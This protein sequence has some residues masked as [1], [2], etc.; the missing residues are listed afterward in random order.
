[1]KSLKKIS[2]IFLLTFFIGMGVFFST[3]QQAN[4]NVLYK[5]FGMVAEVCGFGQH[6]ETTYPQAETVYDIENAILFDGSSDYLSRTPSSSGNTKAWTWSGWVQRSKLG[7]EQYVFNATN[8][9]SENTLIRFQ[10]DDKLNLRIYTG[11]TI[12]GDLI[13]SALYRDAT[14]WMHI[15]AVID[16]DNTIAG[17]RMR[18]YVN[19]VEVTDF[20]TDIN[21]NVGQVSVVN[22][23]SYTHRMGSFEGAQHYHNGYASD[24]YF[25][26]GQALAA[27]DF[28]YEDEYGKWQPKAYAGS[29]GTNGFYLDF[30]DSSNL[31]KDASG[32]GNNWTVNGS[33]EQVTSTPTNTYAT[34]NLLDKDSGV[35]LSN[36]N[37]TATANTNALDVR[38]TIAVNSGKYSFE[39]KVGVNASLT[40][41]G[42]ADTAVLLENSYANGVNYRSDA[43]Q[44]LEGSSSSY[45]DTYT[46]GDLIRGEFDID[47]GTI[48]FFKNN[49]SQGTISFT[50]AGRYFTPFVRFGGS[51]GSGT[52]NFTESAWEN[53]PTS[54]FQALSIKNLATPTIKKANE[55]FEVLTY[56][57]NGSTQTITGTD[58][59][60]VDQLVWMKSRSETRAH[61][62]FDSVRGGG[63]TIYSSA[64]DSEVTNHDRGYLYEFN[65]DGFTVGA[66]AIDAA[67]TN[68]NGEG[69]VAWRWRAGDTQVTNTDGSITS[70][71]SAN[72]QAGFSI[73][74]YTGNGVVGATIG[75]GLGG[76][77]TKIIVKQ[78]N[79]TT[80]WKTYHESLG[81]QYFLRFDT[82][83]AIPDPDRWQNT[84]PTDSVITLGIENTR[85]GYEYIAYVWSEVEGFSKFGSYTGNG[86]TDGPFVYTGF[87]PK[88]VMVKRADGS[89]NWAVLDSERSAYNPRNSI[90]RPDLSSTE[91]SGST[92]DV[93]ILS[94]GVKLRATDG[95]LN[96][97]GGNYIYMAFA[98]EPLKVS[99]NTKTA[100]TDYTNSGDYSFEDGTKLQ[101]ANGVASLKDSGSGYPVDEILTT[102]TDDDGQLNITG[103]FDMEGVDVTETKE[104]VESVGSSV[105]FDETEQQYLTWTPETEG[106]RK[107][108]TMSSWVKRSKLGSAGD[109][110]NPI[111]TVDVNGSQGVGIYFRSD[112]TLE[113]PVQWTG[114]WSGYLRTTPVFRDASD[115]AHVMLAVDTT[116]ETNTNRLKLYVDG[117]QVTSFSTETYP[118]QNADTSFN[119]ARAHEVGKLVNSAHHMDGYLANVHFVD[120]QALEPLNFGQTE[121]ATGKWVPK[122][123][124]G[125]YGTNGFHLDFSNESRLGDDAATHD[126]DGY[127]VLNSLDKSSGGVI[128]NGGKTIASNGSNTNI[129]STLSI[130]ETGKWSFEVNVDVV[131][132]GNAW[133][134]VDK[135][136]PIATNP[137]GY[138]GTI[139]YSSAL[140]TNDVVRFEVDADNSL[141]DIFKNDVLVSAD[142][143]MTAGVEYMVYCRTSTSGEAQSTFVFD[144]SSWTHTPTTGFQALNVNNLPEPSTYNT[145]EHFEVLTWTGTGSAQTIT[146]TDWGADDQLIWLKDRTGT[147][148]HQ[149]TD[150][151]RG[152]S[153]YIYTNSTV[154][155]SGVDPSIVSSINNDGI[156][157]GSAN[158]GNANGS[159]YVAWR[160]RAGQQTANTDGT[161]NSTVSHNPTLGFSI[162]KYTGNGSAGATIG[163]GGSKK[164]AIVIVKDLSNTSNWNI[165]HSALTGHQV[166][167][168]TTGA[169][170]TDY[171]A[172]N[173]TVP[174]SSVFT[175]GTSSQ[176]N[177]SGNEYIAYIF[178]ESDLVKPFSYTGNGSTDGP[179]VYTGGEPLFALNKQTNA[180]G[181]A[182]LIHDKI[183]GEDQGLKPNQN[184]GEATFNALDFEDMGLKNVST[185]STFNASGGS[186][187]GLAIVG[188]Q[189]Q[190][191]LTGND[192]DV[193]GSPEQTSD[194]PT[195]N[196]A[197]LNPVDTNNQTVNF[198]EG[199]LRFVSGSGDRGGVR[200]TLGAANKVVRY[201][202]TINSGAA[203]VRVGF[204]KAGVTWGSV[205][206]DLGN[207][208]GGNSFGF[209]LGNGYWN[210]KTNNSTGHGTITDG[211]DFSVEFNQTTG[212]VIVRNETTSTNVYDT[213]LVDVDGDVWMA[214][215]KE[216]NGSNA[217][218]ITLRFAKDQWKYTPQDASATELSVANLPTPTDKLSNHFETLLYTG[219]GSSQNITGT[220]WGGDDQLVWIKSRN[221][222]FNHSLTD[223]VRGATKRLMSDTTDAENTNAQTLTSFS[224]NGFSVGSNNTENGS[225]TNFVAWRFRAGQQETNND[226]TIEATVSAN[227]TSGFSIV[228]YTGNDTS[229]QSV[230]HGLDTAPG[231]V[232][233]KAL[234]SLNGSQSWQVWH[235]DLTP[236]TFLQLNDTGSAYSE[237]GAPHARFEAPYADDQVFYIGG[238]DAINGSGSEFIAYV[239]AESDFIDIGSYTGN[240]SSDGPFVYMDGKPAFNITKRTDS[241]NNW[242]MTDST[243]SPDNPVN[244]FIYPDVYNAETTGVPID[245]LST[246]IK[247]RTTNAI[248]NASGGSYV[249]LTF[250][251]SLG[252]QNANQKVYYAVSFDDRTTF[253]TWDATVSAWRNIAQLSAGTWAFNSATSG[254]EAWTNCT[255]NDQEDCLSQAFGQSTN[256]MTG[257]QFEALKDSDF[258]KSGGWT[259]DSDTIDVAIGMSTNTTVSTPTVDS[260]EFSYLPRDTQNTSIPYTVDENTTYSSEDVSKAQVANGEAKLVANSGD[261]PTDKIYSVSTSNSSQVDTANLASVNSVDVTETTASTDYE[262]EN[263][264]VLDSSGEYFSKTFSSAESSLKEGTISMWVNPLDLTAGL[265][266]NPIFST[267]QNSSNR[268]LIGWNRPNVG[269]ELLVNFVIN[270]TTYFW[271]S[272]MYFRDLSTPGHLHISWDTATQSMN[273]SWNGETITWANSATLPLNGDVAM[274]NTFEHL[275]GKW[276][277]SSGTK[278]RTSGWSGSDIFVVPAET[279]PT[280]FG[281]INATTGKWEPKAYSGTYGTNGFYLDFSDVTNL[282][283]D[284]SG[285]GNDWTVNGSPKQVT[286]T[287]STVYATLNPLYK[288]VPTPTFS[289]GNLNITAGG[290]Y[291]GAVGT[292]K[293]PTSGKWYYEAKLQS[294]ATNSNPAYIGIAN[295]EWTTGYDS[296]GFQ[297]F[298]WQ[299]QGWAGIS[300]EVE[301]TVVA[302]SGSSATNDIMQVAVDMDNDQ[303]WLGKNN[304]WYDASAGTTGNPLLGLNASITGLLDNIYPAFGMG[305]NGWNVR[306]NESD[307]TYSAPT[308]FAALSTANLPKVEDKLE[309]HFETLLWTGNS[310]NLNQIR[311]TNW[312]SDDQM[313][314]IKGR[315]YTENH[316][317]IDSLRAPNVIYP[318]VTNAGTDTLPITI[319]SDGLDITSSGVN[320]NISGN[321]VVAWRFRA[322]Q[323]AV[324]NDGTIS[325]TVSA[326]TTSG[327]SIVK[328]T[329]NGTAGATIGHGLGEKPGMIIVKRLDA[330]SHWHAYHEDLGAGKYLIFTTAKEYTNTTA[331]NGDEPNTVDITLGDNVDVNADGGEY[332]AYVF[333]DSDFIKTFSYTGNGSADGPFVNLDAEP[334]YSIIKNASSGS[335][336]TI[337]D[338]VRDIY[339]PQ[340]ADLYTDAASAENTNS[341]LY[342]DSL[343]TGLK[344]RNT[345]AG[346]NTSGH[347]YIGLAFVNPF[348]T[349]AIDKSPYYAVSFDDRTTFKIWDTTNSVWKAIVK[350][351]GSTWQY[352]NA[353]SSWTNCTTNTM[354]A[355]LSESFAT[356]G[357]TMTGTVMEAITEDQ[358]QSVG[359]V[360]LTTASINIATGLKTGKV[361]VT[362]KVDNIQFNFTPRVAQEVTACYA[363]TKACSVTNGVGQQEWNSTTETWG[364]CSIVNCNSGYAQSGNSCV[365]GNSLLFNGSNKYLS[366]TPSS[367]GDQKTWTLSTWVKRSGLGVTQAVFGAGT[368]SHGNKYFELTF[369]SDDKLVVT[370]STWGVS[371]AFG[372]KTE[373]TF[374]DVGSWYHIALAM[375]TVNST[376]NL[377]VNGVQQDMVL[378]S[379]ATY[380][381]ANY[382][383]A[384]S[385]ATQ[386][387]LGS[388]GGVS[389]YFDGYH[390]DVY[391]VDGQALAPTAFGQTNTS[392]N[393]WE[394]VAY[395][396]TYGDN[397]F[398][399]DFTD[400]SSTAAL[401]TD[402][403]GNGNDFTVNNFATTDQTSDSPVNNY[404]T[405]NP[406]DKGG[407]LNFS[408]GNN[409]VLSAAAAWTDVRATLGVDSGVWYWEVDPRK[410]GNG[411][412]QIG[413]LGEG[414]VYANGTAYWHNTGTR[415]GA[416]AAPAYGV[417]V[418]DGSKVSSS[419]YTAYGAGLVT[420][421]TLGVKLD[422]DAGTL[423]F[424]KNGVSQGV[425]FTGLTGKFFPAMSV[426]HQNGTN[427]ANQWRFNPDLWQY[428]P[429]GITDSNALSTKN[430]AAP[431]ISKANNYFEVLTYTGNGSSQTI[432]GTDWGGADQLVWAKSRTQTEHHLLYDSVRGS[433]KWIGSNITNATVNEPTGLTSFNNDGFTMG[434]HTYH[435]GSGENYVAWR[436][437]AGDSQVVNNDGTITSTVSANTD[438]GFS[439][440]KYTSNGVAGDTIGHGL[441]NDPEMILIKS[442]SNA[443]SW[444]V[445]HTDLGLG[446]EMYLDLTNT[447]GSGNKITNVT[448]N[449]IEFGV[450][451]DNNA[452]GTGKDYIAYAWSEVEGFSKFGSYTGNGSTDGPFVYTGFKPRYVMLKRADS[453]S[454]WLILDTERDTYNPAQNYLLADQSNAESAN[455]VLDVLSNGFKLRNST[456]GVNGGTMIYMA[457]AEEPLSD[458]N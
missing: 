133:G 316:I 369:H 372:G 410:D 425:A 123:Y 307:W 229:A 404:A 46:N 305:A 139:V 64:T 160:F 19:G 198:S 71:V 157:L 204:M 155:E 17:D 44:Y 61:T 190:K 422:M 308:G 223:S 170:S 183:R 353:S 212:R 255:S 238:N 87:K 18:L 458:N 448:S 395:T 340:E 58:W 226:G 383:T 50:P 325:A 381:S 269:S 141:V 366:W 343:S 144:E 185:N 127:A 111:L 334:N 378:Y 205:P 347:Q 396:G 89:T 376:Y 281:E 209:R 197:M 246:G 380:P 387:A 193:V 333:T 184:V 217:G 171:N 126:G 454:S 200:S 125:E 361:T 317:V 66:G 176:L 455:G 243:R 330:V 362:P 182:W 337:R 228:K 323:S 162:V 364:S 49:V 262:I 13:T 433:Q 16:T 151:V 283:K 169:I 99:E 294:S 12:V 365:P 9:G 175:V 326:N 37:R 357:N 446:K 453:T 154:A 51:S 129:R 354:N 48:E 450:N 97:S 93:D 447:V 240:G 128:S 11:S 104:E 436:W 147:N 440:V 257:A 236:G 173:N 181:N 258:N 285:N 348:Q 149:L 249:Y 72:K 414:A 47:A 321:N 80:P 338:S 284:V 224:N 158:Q 206:S 166:L 120:G 306:F 53:T 135:N 379:V 78:T 435:N 288:R 219:N 54:G 101:V 77:P 146:G 409:T 244:A 75:H 304:T 247:K 331:W 399:L 98:E 29:Y 68:I 309:N 280:S 150:T 368:P 350:K 179:F 292:I 310:T 416:G 38:S 239:F 439:I 266:E 96:A 311:G 22:S 426:Y 313:I 74:K 225:G 137:G 251:E 3:P 83:A 59:G 302:S 349:K 196:Y 191:T 102:V 421:D 312:G 187:I 342:V 360:G 264:V 65:T 227:T 363:D 192:F 332:I 199:N 293:L 134:L 401:G 355:C 62:L 165:W 443:H 5:F 412:V 345:N 42:I 222:A 339:N 216:E 28:G 324:N 188:Q 36:G 152:A 295:E 248:Y 26:D 373:G 388:F 35:T 319:Q 119:L 428:T 168:F 85:S 437:R 15:V 33:P 60:G 94:N 210:Y 411:T 105:V 270:G 121:E 174:S 445:W 382:D 297:G 273:A 356:A 275:I 100:S 30:S 318:S 82:G 430:L 457:F 81:A 221:S 299:T 370:D 385:S 186:Y 402:S 267:Y 110:Y 122:A 346:F 235:K 344:I 403:S 14:E 88:Y 429:V 359:G 189:P 76:K 451:N 24:F 298:R 7:S 336:W 327:F 341:T 108:F 400:N 250:K 153:K 231:M 438:A 300:N 417:Q 124:S 407:N 442:T 21:P 242:F 114:S 70:T 163:H 252:S 352:L 394:P 322:G 423:E 145:N 384:M 56:T 278:V 391:F 142:V 419:G 389:G 441:G 218:D 86:S 418:Y 10:S 90:L 52:F 282:G 296:V 40:Q 32:N 4:A 180:T 367:A 73:V 57:G 195:N 272:N 424:F 6:E 271:K 233:V 20:S 164:P 116:E 34:L 106:N 207:E 237:S 253:K 456:S 420:G 172:W 351:F 286:N 265:D 159:N 113:I 241:T 156:S 112:D 208:T 107:T 444:T 386:Q 45:G 103:A 23:T 67:Y 398:H 413:V 277:D 406:L 377:Y 84:E 214:A 431:T 405:M 390:S 2:F 259:N 109:T 213:T 178:F 314:W 268:V 130:P 256:Q 177:T 320:I 25:V 289:D 118:S 287:P 393:K 201:E 261:Y 315:N 43:K 1:M 415:G 202:G 39:Y 408:N 375:D 427:G 392:N 301:A 291:Y 374:T 31:G 234:D 138:P 279:T 371:T 335:N 449:T 63:K 358:W 232:I 140:T 161:I 136:M 303:I 220:D 41:V 79:G 55:H 143:S 245:F 230:G 92:Q 263:G 8:G 132:G 211:Q 397:G 69:Y 260:V 434:G 274:F 148:W 276:T 27:T 115:W 194:T 131:G 254:A 117:N 329:G 91:I 432:T 290:H 452:N 203:Y 167:N 215:V 328:Y 95:K